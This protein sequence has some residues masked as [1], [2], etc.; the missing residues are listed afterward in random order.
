M[1]HTVRP[2]IVTGNGA[3][4]YE[5]QNEAVATVN[6]SLGRVHIV[7]VGVARIYAYL[8][9]TSNYLGAKDFCEVTVVAKPIDAGMVGAIANQTYTGGPLLPSVVVT[10]GD[11]TNYVLQDGK[12][13]SVNI[14][15]YVPN[16]KA[17]LQLPTA[18]PSHAAGAEGHA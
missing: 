13:K 7:G 12:F 17:H 5:S 6:S 10:D 16:G 15:A 18:M 1:P 8:S 2:D 9:G 3:L 4:T 11:W 14:N